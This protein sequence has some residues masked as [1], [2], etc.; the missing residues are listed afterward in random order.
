[1]SDIKEMLRRHEGERLKPYK[2]PAGK[3][4]IGVGWNFDANPLPKDI[5]AY[6]AA[7]GQITKGMSERLLDISIATA[8]RNCIEL[9]PNFKTFSENRQNALIDFVFNVGPGTALKF[10][11]TLTFIRTGAWDLAAA[12]MAKSRWYEQVGSRA[13]EIV[14]MIK[15]G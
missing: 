6:L 12:N 10:R 9:F 14:K 1:M 15:E 3:N 11:N 13:K 8:R 4:T 5:A 2:C 7:H